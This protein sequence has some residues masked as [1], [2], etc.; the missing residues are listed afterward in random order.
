[1][2]KLLLIFCLIA[3]NAFAFDE[4]SKTDI[5]LQSVYTVLHVIDWG[6]TRY[7]TTQRNISVIKTNGNTCYYGPCTYSTQVS[8]IETNFILGKF[9]SKT[10]VD[11]YFAST[12]VLHTAISYILPKPYRTL[13]QAGTIGL[14]AYVINNNFNVGIHG[15]F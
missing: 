11:L 3:S 13:W 6:Q 10:E 5:A 15:M 7:L 2:K 1:M 12:L 9:P 14:E 4:W 8:K